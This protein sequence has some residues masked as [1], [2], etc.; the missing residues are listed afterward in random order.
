MRAESEGPAGSD[1]GGSAAPRDPVWRRPRF[2]LAV[3]VAAFFVVSLYA[4]IVAYTNFQTQNSTDAGIIT[5][6][7]ASTAHGGVAPFYESYDCQVK[8]RC[9]FLLVHTGFVLYVAVPFYALL[10][11]TVTLFALRSL[12]VALAALP[13]YSL[14]RQVTGSSKKGL[15]AA[16]MWLFWAPQFSADA[17][18]LHLE[19]L[20]PIEMFSLAALWQAGRYRWGL[21]V[22]GVSFL[23]FEINPLFTFL[24]GI[25]F[26]FPYLE[27]RARSAW[28]AWRTRPQRPSGVRA[29]LGRLRNSLSELWSHREVRYIAALLAASAAAYVALSLF[30]NVFGY[31]ILGVIEPPLRAPGIVGVFANNSSPPAHSP[32]V[33]LTSSQSISTAEYWLILYA[34]LG[35]VPL[36][37]VRSLILSVPWIGWTFLT[38]SSRF[39]T[40]GHQYSMIAAA[41]LFI[42]LAYG[43]GRVHF[44]KSAPAPT[45]SAGPG[46][47][48]SP[49]RG[50]RWTLESGAH[51]WAWAGVFGAVFVA[52]A[53]VMP[54]NPLLSDLGVSLRAPFEPDYFDHSLTVSP[55][56]AWVE[57]MVATIPYS[58]SIAA[59]SAVFP[60][61]ANYP[62]AY[63][64]A[65]AGAMNISNLPINLSRGPE[66]ALVTSQS[67]DAY[68]TN[69]SRNISDPT[70]YG[71][72]GWVAGTTLGPL[73]L[74]ERGYN[75]T[76]ELFG[77][78][79]GFTSG[80]YLPGHGISAGPRGELVS[81]PETPGGAII[82]SQNLS[83]P[84][85]LIW[86]GP[87]VLVS[88]GNY[89][90]EVS[91][92]ILGT[93]SSGSPVTGSLKLV[94]AGVGGTPI[95]ATY[96]VAQFQAKVWT[97]LVYNVTI[98][99]PL[100]DFYLRGYLD[101][102]NTGVA[103]AE[104]RLG[105]S[106]A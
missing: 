15:L 58:A 101:S 24:I 74:F 40:L 88:P 87:D 83:D 67:F 102:S 25:F 98:S 10:P 97:I 91:V 56:F 31:E 1:I 9:S 61:V 79:P 72:R 29:A 65:P 80:T 7:V 50:R 20:I 76:P 19:S 106:A 47:E 64:L 60:I 45:E 77:P 57:E 82:Q 94:G 59:P 95:N 37:S 66:F 69:L 14:T 36:L 55:A 103:V 11:S 51:R 43:L 71:V 34:L 86:T 39:T 13:L 78:S 32:I 52:N 89:T 104:I 42:G 70:D 16:G 18:S 5:Q 2:W 3:A 85:G 33:V 92:M 96:P 6:A 53:L 26:L 63:V 28:Q 21:V 73:L 17:F 12:F 4:G 93:N 46:A 48:V 44:E 38:V 81:D 49:R 105:P 54:V 35:F 22:A 100:L 62:H 84:N 8:D 27:A 90:I 23:T 75:G 41:P 68:G 99:S 30:T